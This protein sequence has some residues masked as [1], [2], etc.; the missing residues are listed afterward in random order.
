ML[1]ASLFRTAPS[2]YVQ[3]QKAQLFH[4]YFPPQAAAHVLSRKFNEFS[5]TSSVIHYVSMVKFSLKYLYQLFASI[6]MEYFVDL[7]LKT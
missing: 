7:I 5:W 3:L 2:K 1:L 6:I 4:T